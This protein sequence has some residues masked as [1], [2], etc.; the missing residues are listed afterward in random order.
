MAVSV[1]ILPSQQLAV[2]TEA[3]RKAVARKRLHLALATAAFFLPA[4]RSPRLAR[5]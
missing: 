4:W 3:Y 5:K 2:L 1:P